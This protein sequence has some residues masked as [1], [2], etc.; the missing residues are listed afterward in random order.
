MSYRAEGLHLLDVWGS[1]QTPKHQGRV[2][3]FSLLDKNSLNELPVGDVSDGMKTN[4]L[5]IVGIAAVT[6]GLSSCAYDSYYG[7][8]GHPRSSVAVGYGHGYG[9]GG[10]SFTSSQFWT[11]GN[12][13]WGY[14][15]HVRCYYDF[16]R[17]AYFDPVLVGYYPVGYRPPVLVGVPH[18][19][20]YRSG[21]CPP[22]RNVTNIT[23]VNYRNRESAYRNTNHGWARN[24]RYDARH[25]AANPVT[26]NQNNQML[27]GTAAPGRGGFTRQDQAGAARQNP[28]NR[29]GFAGPANP[30][31]IQPAV[32][33]TN[34]SR[35]DHSGRQFGNHRVERPSITPQ[36]PPARQNPGLDPRRGGNPRNFDGDAR[37]NRGSREGFE[38][39]SRQVTRPETGM[40]ARQ[41]HGQSRR[42]GGRGAEAIPARPNPRPAPSNVAPANP[43]PEQGGPRG[44]RGGRDQQPVSAPPA[45]GDAGGGQQPGRVPRR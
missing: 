4:L 40:P 30:R 18:P 10:R 23:L 27:A 35:H 19:S 34:P 36:T 6:L 8:G 28:A 45:D 44:Q 41:H 43:R 26:R 2:I 12:P 16:D 20:G 39:G 22:P 38:R 42:E 13:R 1:L 21:W 24:V 3:Q 37:G 31:P 14:D 32:N 5:S 17:R 29:G 33:R 25:R 15:P 7:G 9:Y 11:T